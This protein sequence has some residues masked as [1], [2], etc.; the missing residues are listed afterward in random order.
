MTP[1]PLPG[2]SKHEQKLS[3]VI[4]AFLEADQSGKAGDRDAW[5]RRYPDL[6]DDLRRF[7]EQHDRMARLAA[8]LRGADPTPT[9]DGSA[10]TQPPRASEGAAP[11]ARCSFADY[12][13][14][15]EIARGAMGVV[16]KARQVG[17]NREVALKMILAGELASQQDVARFRAE[18]EAVAA[19]D[20]P[21]IL[22]IYEV[23][24]RDGRHFFAMKLVAGGSLDDRIKALRPTPRQA[25]QLLATVAGAV[26][27][28]HQR[29]ILHRDLKPSNVLLDEGGAPF[30][31]DFGLAKKIEGD[32]SLT[33][34]GAIVGTP[35]YMAPEQAAA[36][37]GLTV[38]VDVYA[39][40]A[41]LYTLLTGRPPFR[42]DNIM[43]TL[44]QV[45]EQ[46]PA[47][48]CFLNSR[49]PRDLET[50]CLKCLEKDPARRY[51][52]AREL[53][54]DLGRYLEGEPVRARPVGRLERGWKWCRR[55]PLQASLAVA[56]VL[57]VLLLVGGSVALF[58][59]SKVRG[60]NTQLQGALGEAQKQRG[61]AEKQR[62]DADEQRQE[63][64]R[65]K[66]EADKVGQEL[67]RK[68]EEIGKKNE[69]IE[70]QKE[71][72]RRA[73]F[74][75]QMKFADLAWQQNRMADLG[76][77]LDRYKPTPGD[78]PN[79]SLRRFEWDS[80]W[81]LYD[82]DLPTLRGHKGPVEGVC[83]SPDG[84][85]L[86][87]ACR[88]GSVRVWDAKRGQQILAPEGRIGGATATGV[89]FSPDGTLLAASSFGAVTVWDARTG[90]EARTLGTNDWFTSVCF[91]PDGKRVAA[92]T[93]K[94]TGAPEAGEVKVWDVRTGR[95]ELSLKGHKVPVN[96]VCWSPDG[97]RL[98]SAGAF[99]AA[100]VKVWDAR[101]GREDLSLK[102]L[103]GQVHT[104]CWSPDGDILATGG[105]DQT[106]TVWDARTGKKVGILKGHTS[107]VK[108][109]CFSPDGT[110]LASAGDGEFGR[111]D[112]GGSV[113]VWDLRTG[114]E[115]RSFKGYT[116]VCWS[117]DGTRL[118]SA[119]DDLSSVKL[120][121]ACI[122]QEALALHG[123]RGWVH[124]VCFSP[125]GTRLASAAYD[126][127]VKVWDAR[128]GEEARTLAG[129]TGKV[130]SVCFSPDG[131]RLA[132][133]GGDHEA[134]IGEVKVWDARTGRE[135]LS[136]DGLKG[137][138]RGLCWSPDGNCLAIAGEGGEITLWDTSTG[139]ALLPL[140]GT[141]AEVSCVAFSPDGTRLAAAGLGGMNRVQADQDVELTEDVRQLLPITVGRVPDGRRPD[142]DPADDRQEA[143]RG[144]PE[145]HSTS[146][147]E[148]SIRPRPALRG[149]SNASTRSRK[150]SGPVFD[151]PKAPDPFFVAKRR[152]Q[153]TSPRSHR[154]GER[155]RVHIRH[156]PSDGD[157]QRVADALHVDG[158]VAER[159]HAVD[160][161]HGQGA[162]ERAAAGV[163]ANRQR[164]RVAVVA[165]Y[166]VAELI[167][168]R[169]EHRA[170]RLPGGRVG[171][172]LQ[173]QQ[174]VG[175]RGIDRDSGA[176]G[177]RAADRVG[178]CD[179]LTSRR[180]QCDAKSAGAV[181]EGRVGRQ[182]SLAITAGEMDRAGVAG[183]RVVEGILG[184]HGDAERRTR[185][186]AAGSA[187]AEVISR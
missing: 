186:G 111:D 130:Y 159:R 85:R 175:R 51:A 35:A 63:A 123:H 118:A 75:A 28:A 40:G 23:G 70:T 13:I 116:C 73:L 39:L 172:L 44:R 31:V 183:S 129:H 18:A 57:L 165:R 162:A 79:K 169:D 107:S 166:D 10:D 108:S 87:S 137:P 158:Q 132:S 90:R 174:V 153:N 61:E 113:R 78:D 25:A 100:E 151:G 29:G 5:L 59:Y 146:P 22:P 52:T 27:F 37:K 21:N 66:A 47:P 110:L 148:V 177:G 106:V 60:L 32:S 83:W 120:W 43:E 154:D 121:D 86:A 142:G 104:V 176:A 7:F 33:Q 50:I 77:I 36:K 145:R 167:D 6:A 136:V 119:G 124:G 14:L 54:D 168:N 15:A 152:Q 67:K 97:T 127:R 161:R 171:R 38:A 58:F 93:E 149:Q 68:N 150:G 96:S 144:A 143:V 131:N 56:S 72:V 126:G 187:H 19:L 164:D 99:V 4:A 48:P 181:G 9:V 103:K 45:V 135:D 178:G 46:E 114:R 3:E 157:V 8:P 115:V 94:Q 80:L 156:G 89:C 11:E 147:N 163:A 74:G 109:V 179:R 55:H 117:P 65:R 42:G 125:D 95:E 133:A 91:S 122:G 41:I 71:L 92:T 105:G 180:L 173:E 1:P 12:E 17:L 16:Y 84:T 155:I 170:D 64:V 182:H 49:V 53:A 62:D 101:T 76:R 26:H 30:V 160:H 141:I 134:R 81:R 34:S 140:D 185:S 24:E 128:T 112:Q 184:R 2:A 82:G 20:H 98:A 69:E 88:D 139:E 102:D 138:V